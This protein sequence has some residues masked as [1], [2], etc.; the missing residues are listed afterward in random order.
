MFR[1]F[2]AWWIGQL[3]HLLPQRW[4]RLGAIGEDALVI[5]PVGSPSREVDSIGINLRRRG[6][7]GAAASD[8]DYIRKRRNVSRQIIGREVISEDNT[9]KLGRIGILNAARCVAVGDRAGAV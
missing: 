7:G 9:G 2:F 3:S 4:G 1:D 6:R 8:A 5:G